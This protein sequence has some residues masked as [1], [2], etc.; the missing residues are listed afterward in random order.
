MR[1]KIQKRRQTDGETDRQEAD[2][3]RGPD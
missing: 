3:D 1:R 2:A